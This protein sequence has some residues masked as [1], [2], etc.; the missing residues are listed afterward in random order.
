MDVNVLKQ[1]FSTGIKEL[2]WYPLYLFPY[3]ISL[4]DFHLSTFSQLMFL[5]NSHFGYCRQRTL[6]R[7]IT[8]QLISNQGKRGEHIPFSQAHNEF[9]F[10]IPSIQD[11]GNSRIQQRL[12]TKN[13]NLKYTIKQSSRVS[14]L[15][16]AGFAA[17]GDGMQLSSGSLQRKSIRSPLPPW[18]LI[19]MRWKVQHLA[20]L[21]RKVTLLQHKVVLSLF[22]KSRETGLG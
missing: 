19:V 11:G 21:V 10:R 3:L 8:L 4:G 6:R 22:I 20:R 2:Y 14:C 1:V 7:G 18:L 13:G 5:S 16:Q 9:L 12:N 17:F 15:A